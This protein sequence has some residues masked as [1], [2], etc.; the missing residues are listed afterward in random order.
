MRKRMI[1]ATACLLFAFIAPAACSSY[2][3]PQPGG[4]VEPSYNTVAVAPPELPVYEQPA[5][6]GDT[7]I[8]TPGYW[9]WGGNDYYWVPGTWVEAPEVGVLWTP[10]YWGWG[11]N[12]FVFHEGYWGP[13]VGFY[14]GVNYG[15]G[16]FGHGFEGGHWDNGRFFHNR[17][18][19]NVDVTIIHN[20][21]NTTV[22]NNTVTRVSYNGGN[23]GISARPTPEEQTAAQARHIPPVA[24]Q[25]QHVQ[26]A[27]SNPQLQASVNHGLP[28]I[29]ATPKPG[30]FTESGVVPAKEAGAINTSAALP[31]NNSGSLNAAVHPKDLPPVEHPAA[32]NTGSPKVDQQYQQ[33]Q[34]KLL[35]QQAQER[36][37]LQQKQD[38]DH[39][40][41]AQQKANDAAMQQLEQ[42]HQQETQQ[43]VQK[44]AQQQQKLRD[45]QQ[46]PHQ[47]EPKPTKDKP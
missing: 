29:A 38:Q 25:T 41:L 35:A 9:A 8:W 14:G 39:Q 23:G 4:Y 5:C 37:K 10:G 33:E 7:Y 15:Y 18:V 28:P 2:G 22:V 17:S 11:G 45:H 31:A 13:Q 46:P 12:G 16:Y 30:A 24:V 32:P 26:A 47:D 19:S 3:G 1:A 42:R 43:L 34:E 20:V 27:R 44:H 6:P 21:Y 36:Q 40:R